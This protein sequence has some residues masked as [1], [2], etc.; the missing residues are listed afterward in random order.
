VAFAKEHVD[1]Y[2]IAHTHTQQA[3]PSTL[4]HYITGVAFVVDRDI[5]R[6][7][8]AFA[9]ANRSAMGAAAITTSGFPINR[10]TMRALLGFD[11]V[12]ENSYDAVGGGDYLGEAAAVVH[13]CCV[14]MSRLVC[15][16]LLWATQEFGYL[17]VAAPYVQI[18]SIMPQKRNPVSI[19]HARS[20][21][22]SA[23]GDCLGVLSMLH[24]TPYGDI[25]DTEDDAQPGLWRAIG[26]L[27]GIY[28]LMRN[29]IVTLDV[30]KEEMAR[31]AKNSFAV[32]TELA[33]TLVREEKVP[34]RQAHSV[35]F[36]LVSHCTSSGITLSD[37]S[38]ELINTMFEAV[39]GRVLSA[40]QE[41]IKSSLS[42]IH[43]VTVRNR[44]GGTE[45]NELLRSFDDCLIP[46]VNENYQ[47]IHNKVQLIEHSLDFMQQSF[48][49]L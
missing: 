1:T 45:R 11:E 3:Q 37:V 8:R 42:Y 24:N 36:K 21:L 31:R 10:E 13:L 9:C 18:S 5:K 35:A 48:S 28:R 26:K 22:S 44:E 49:K 39:S 17:K 43:F 46:K 33:D 29:V 14:N 2:M 27:G 12:I 7:G 6:L 30:D 40:P 19:E 23:I 34:F 25:V 15:D 4:G 16:L 41:I 47:W 38:I 20:L 32:I